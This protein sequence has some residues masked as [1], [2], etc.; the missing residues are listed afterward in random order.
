MVSLWCEL[1][2]KL[3]IYTSKSNQWRTT[4]WAKFELECQLLIFIPLNSKFKVTCN[5][6]DFEC[7]YIRTHT[8]KKKKKK[9]N[10]KF[11]TLHLPFC[12]YLMKILK[13]NCH[14]K[15]FGVFFSWWNHYMHFKMVHSNTKTTKS[16]VCQ[17]QVCN[18]CTTHSSALKIFSKHILCPNW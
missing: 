2:F 6:A 17:S 9:N 11:L 1:L 4:W 10:L 5:S 7:R 8:E 3:S 16:I 12:L 15:Y 18:L 14:P 13:L